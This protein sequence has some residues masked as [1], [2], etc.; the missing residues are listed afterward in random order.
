ML[1]RDWCWIIFPSV[2][3]AVQFQSELGGTLGIDPD[4]PFVGL[5]SPVELVGGK[6]GWVCHYWAGIY[7]DEEQEAM[8]D[9]IEILATESRYGGVVTF[10]RVPPA[11]WQVLEISD[12]P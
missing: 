3:K 2:A 6:A 10:G 4:V 9:Q 12:D 8:R 7:P 1:S 5:S 11:D